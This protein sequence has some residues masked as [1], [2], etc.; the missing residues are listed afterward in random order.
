MKNK[1]VIHWHR[2]EG[3]SPRNPEKRFAVHNKF[4]DNLQKA[5]DASDA[6]NRRFFKLNPDN[7]EF[8]FEAKEHLPVGVEFNE[9]GGSD[10]K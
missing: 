8:K 4:Y 7:P 6:L 3:W 10:G 5:K 9:K 2:I 1:K